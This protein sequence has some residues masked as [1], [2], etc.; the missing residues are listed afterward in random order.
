MEDVL[1]KRKQWNQSFESHM[2]STNVFS[3]KGERWTMSSEYVE[4]NARI[5]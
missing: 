4:N 3:M 5:P 2:N 1:K